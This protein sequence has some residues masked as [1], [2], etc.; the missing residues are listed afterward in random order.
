VKGRT[1]LAFLVGWLLAP[2]LVGLAIV[3]MIAATGSHHPGDTLADTT[4]KILFYAGLIGLPVNLL[5]MAALV[6]P[7]WIALRKRGA[8]AIA[9]G[10]AGGVIGALLGLVCLIGPW[11]A[12]ETGAAFHMALMIAV[13][14]A[15]GAVCLLLMRK[16]AG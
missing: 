12:G 15:V 11:T 16:I 3:A 13:P 6:L 7:T 9:F 1:F 8:G 10:V 2:L 5:V 14:A 4:A